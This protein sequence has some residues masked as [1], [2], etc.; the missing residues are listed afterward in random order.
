MNATS[1]SA[2]SSRSLGPTT[3]H[4]PGAGRAGRMTR[5]RRKIR[6]A[7]WSARRLARCIGPAGGKPRGRLGRPKEAGQVLAPQGVHE[8]VDCLE[9]VDTGQHLVVRRRT[10]RCGHDT[11]RAIGHRC[12]VRRPVGEDL[13]VRPHEAGDA[14]Q[15]V[16]LR[17]PCSEE[18]TRG[19]E[20]LVGRGVL[21]NR[22]RHAAIMADD[23]TPADR[24][25]SGRGR[26][27]TRKVVPVG[28]VASTSTDPPLATISSRA[29]VSPIP[30]PGVRPRDRSAR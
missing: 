18:R 15:E 5:C 12:K 26:Q 22:E 13:G 7:T 1:Q 8:R 3:R 9:L 20:E 19:S 4:L 28:P 21:S 11:P 29:T 30:L 2:I 14:E 17:L 23:A 27:V 6:S 16:V 24:P 10:E 25:R